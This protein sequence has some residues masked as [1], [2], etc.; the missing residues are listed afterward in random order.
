M[1]INE[2]IKRTTVYSAVSSG[3][4]ANSPTH[5]AAHDPLNKNEKQPILTEWECE[6]ETRVDFIVRLES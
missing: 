3:V 2:I 6:N 4:I 1:T 5:L